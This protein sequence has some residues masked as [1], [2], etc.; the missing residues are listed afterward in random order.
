[1]NNKKIPTGAGTIVLIIIAVTVFGVVWKYEKNQQ[2][3]QQPLVMINAKKQTITQPATVDQRNIEWKTYKNK[4]LGLS[5]N[6]PADWGDIIVENGNI[7]NVGTPPCKAPMMM[8]YLQKQYPWGLYNTS[9]KFSKVPIDFE[10]RLANLDMPSN[11]KEVCNVKGDLIKTSDIQP[12]V[13]DKEISITNKS[14]IVFIYD[15]SL[16]NSINTSLEGPTYATRHNNKLIWIYSGFSPR[17]NTPE[18]IELR[19][20]TNTPECQGG[21]SY[22]TDKGCGIVAWAQ[23]GK[24]STKVRES[25][26]DLEELVQS[27][28][29]NQ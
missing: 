24:T 29:F 9:L 2:N 1:M 27:F 12:K 11:P 23:A 8:S 6:Y 18:E 7:D 16:R 19:K 22:N 15:S 26:S 10:I 20:Y 4:L 5:F 3:I 21:N 28:A 17:Y 13:Q 14:G 25:F